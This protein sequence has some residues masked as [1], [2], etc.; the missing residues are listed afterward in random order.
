L[1]DADWTLVGTNAEIVFAG[2]ILPGQSATLE[3]T[4]TINLDAYGNSITNVSEISDDD[5][6]LY[7]ITDGDS[8]PDADN[9][10]DNRGDDDQTD[11]NG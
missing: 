8:D 11:G 5:S 1:N 9:T 3:I 4:Y 2:P 10:N 7:N 6:E